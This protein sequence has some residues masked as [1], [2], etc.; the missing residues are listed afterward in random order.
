M[1]C[2]LRI[3]A[4]TVKEM[5]LANL[6]DEEIGRYYQVKR[7]TIFAFR[8]KHKITRPKRKPKRTKDSIE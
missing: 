4:D 2:S 3:C 1:P 8:K 7:Q 6:S 5:I